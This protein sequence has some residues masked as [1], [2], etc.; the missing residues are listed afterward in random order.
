[1]SNLKKKKNQTRFAAIKNVKN[2]DSEKS[3]TQR[4]TISFRSK[5]DLFHSTKW[6]RPFA[7]SKRQTDDAANRTNIGTGTIASFA[8]VILNYFDMCDIEQKFV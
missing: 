8:Q 5:K 1:M 6:K 7:L 2:D 4:F 3:F